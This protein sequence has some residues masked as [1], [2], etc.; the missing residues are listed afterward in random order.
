MRY[1]IELHHHGDEVH[2]HVRI[3]G[4]AEPMPFRSW[5][6]LLRL[7]ESPP[8]SSG[9]SEPHPPGTKHSG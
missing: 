8:P 7:L 9:R 2:G 4:Y 5:L 6:E 1:I 3:D